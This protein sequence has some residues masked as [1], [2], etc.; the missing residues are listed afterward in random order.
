MFYSYLFSKKGIKGDLVLHCQF[1]IA[2]NFAGG[3]FF[4][5]AAVYSKKPL[6]IYNVSGEQANRALLREADEVET[7]RGEGG[8]ESVNNFQFAYYQLFFYP[9]HMQHRPN[10]F[11]KL[12]RY[13]SEKGLSFVGWTSPSRISMATIRTQSCRIHSLLSFSVYLSLTQPQNVFNISLPSSTFIQR[14]FY[15]FPLLLMAEPLPSPPPLPT[16]YVQ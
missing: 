5:E 4:P 2:P 3:S 16:H 15:L 11:R 6:L 13:K 1:S 14:T 7:R 12:G 9:A 10:E 8:R